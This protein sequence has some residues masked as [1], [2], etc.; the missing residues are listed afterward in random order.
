MLCIA[1]SGGRLMQYAL[2]DIFA[3]ALYGLN[4]RAVYLCKRPGGNWILVLISQT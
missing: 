4:H 3:V 2:V 1:S